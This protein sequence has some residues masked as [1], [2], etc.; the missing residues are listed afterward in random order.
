MNWNIAIGLITFWI[1]AGYTIIAH[2]YKRV[3]LWLFLVLISLIASSAVMVFDFTFAWY[4]IGTVFGG[5]GAGVA[6][7]TIMEIYS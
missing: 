1:S 3:A 7:N 6:I 4:L 5:A 2:R